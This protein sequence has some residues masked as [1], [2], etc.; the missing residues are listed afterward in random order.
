MSAIGRYI[1]S[2]FPLLYFPIVSSINK[3]IALS[4]PYS[5]YIT[6]GLGGSFKRY[7]IE[8]EMPSKIK[9]LKN[10]LEPES[11][12][13]VDV[14]LTR[15]LHYPDESNRITMTKNRAVVGGLL[16][17]EERSSK[18]LINQQLKET[19]GS[20][21]LARGLMEES[22]F[23][24]FHGL[25]LLPNQ[26]TARLK[27]QHFIDIG[28]YIG[29]SAIALNSYHYSKVFSLEISR[30]SAERFFSNL[31]KSS[32]S[33]DKYELINMGVAATDNEPPILMFDTGSAGFSTYRKTGKYDKI[34]VQRKSLD[35]IVEQ[36]GIEPKFIKVDIEG[37]AMDF[38]TGA[39]KTLIKFRPVLSIAIYHNPI[40]F[41]EVK[42]T[43]EQL[44]M[45]YTFLIRKL[46]SEVK[47]NQI[48]S[49]VVLL[50]YPNEM[51][52][53]AVLENRALNFQRSIF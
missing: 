11:I 19:A 32:I 3:L 24:F 45:D 16:P 49:E 5:I 14:I 12:N 47:F 46:S 44:L 6:D 37:A 10:G 13:V 50:A 1:K 2:Q 26:V 36:Y 39:K 35:S 29:D 21:K 34:E 38:V 42:P 15:L 51:R 28:A 30:K 17:V 53:G 7:F 48:H 40:E 18:D 9:A 25:K 23:Y 52:E 8:R 33:S 20:I 22:V 43:L 4:R 31:S 27:G 41:F